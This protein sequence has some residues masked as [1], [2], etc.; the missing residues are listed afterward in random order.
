M[1]VF[2]HPGAV[3]SDLFP[4][5]TSHLLLASRHGDNKARLRTEL[6]LIENKWCSHG[7]RSLRSMYSH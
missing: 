4:L 1:E 3:N 2:V 5:P 6:S 7:L